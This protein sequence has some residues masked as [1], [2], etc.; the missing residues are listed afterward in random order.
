VFDAKKKTYQFGV[1]A[2]KIVMCFLI[3]KGYKILF[4]RYK[5]YFGEI[6]II[7][8]KNKVIAII[9]VKA[10]KS[11][12]SIEEVFQMKQA[13]RINKAAEFFLTKNPQFR[14]YEVRFDFV[15]LNRF[16]LLKHFKRFW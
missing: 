1:L 7:A 13:Y 16:F 2:E 4:W 11:K 5:T 12:S 3:L 8:K 14:K 10:R 6:D 9:E 15:L